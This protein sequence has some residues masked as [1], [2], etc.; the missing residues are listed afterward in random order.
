[1]IR[2]LWRAKGSRERGSEREAEGP[3]LDP[4]PTELTVQAGGYSRCGGSCHRTVEQE[5]VGNVLTERRN[6]EMTSTNSSR[7]LSPRGQLMSLTGVTGP[8][9]GRWKA[10]S[11]ARA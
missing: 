11:L 3:G 9:N 2:S 7:A 6:A 10:C 8:L 4:A 5:V 1:M